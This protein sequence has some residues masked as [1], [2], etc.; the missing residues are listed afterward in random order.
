M[1]PQDKYYKAF[2]DGQIAYRMEKRLEDNPYNYKVPEF[3][4]WN[5]GYKYAA[6]FFET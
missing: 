1:K 5:N 2:N 6:Q 3:M 4:Y